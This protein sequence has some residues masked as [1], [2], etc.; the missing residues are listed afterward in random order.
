MLATCLIILTLMGIGGLIRGAFRATWGIFGFFIKF[1]VLPA[2]VI[3]LIYLGFVYLIIP[4]IIAIG[5][6][7][8][9]KYIFK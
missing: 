8:L 6:M 5:V 3:A 1:L 9:V 2:L 4:L 7:L